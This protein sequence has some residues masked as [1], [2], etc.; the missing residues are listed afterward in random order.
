MRV[1]L[2]AVFIVAPLMILDGLVRAT[3]NRILGLFGYE[4]KW[5]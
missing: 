2:V 3:A 4:R 1:W 5:K